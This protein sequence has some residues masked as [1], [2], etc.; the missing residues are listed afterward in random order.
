MSPWDAEPDVEELTFLERHPVWEAQVSRRRIYSFDADTRRALTRLEY[1]LEGENAPD[2]PIVME[3]TLQLYDKDAL[4][5]QVESA[6][7]RI[8]EAYGGY[9]KQIFEV[10]MDNMILVTEA[11]GASD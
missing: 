11:V 1:R 2:S 6:G 8:V 9:G 3:Y 10:G 4:Y 5:E 7:L